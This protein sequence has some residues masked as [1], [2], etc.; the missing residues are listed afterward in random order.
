MSAI[1]HWLR[2]TSRW[3]AL[4]SSWTRQLATWT[5]EYEAQKRLRKAMESCFGVDVP[6]GLRR[7]CL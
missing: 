5:L 7:P 1:V 2:C 6:L 3:H 4:K